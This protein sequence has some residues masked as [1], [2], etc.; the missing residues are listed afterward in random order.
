MKL[1]NKLNL[2][3]PIFEAIKNSG[4]SRGKSDYTATQLIEPARIGALKA[5]HIDELEEDVSNQIFSL[6]GQSVHTILERAAK[7]LN[8][9][10]GAPRYIIEERLFVPLGGLTIS[11]QIDI[12]D[13]KEQILQ[14]YK[15]TSV[16]SVKGKPKK[17]WEEQ[18][19]IGA[20]LLSCQIPSHIVKKLEIVA[21]LRDWSKMEHKRELARGN[22]LGV[23]CT[24]SEHQ[25]VVVDI[26]LWTREKQ[27]A[28]IVKK[29]KEHQAAKKELPECSAEDRWE[30]S[31]KYALMKPGRKSALRLFDTLA[32]AEMA[33]TDAPA[34]CYIDKRP[35]EAIRCENYCPVSN[36]CEQFKKTKE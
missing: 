14:D 23:S 5:K 26:P 12:Y 25:T 9:L 16:H 15:I 27:E 8:K 6:I 32:A 36:F 3:L 7:T 13:I 24:Y 11:G 19:N 20:Y 29:V 18:L 28:F 30:R 33:L 1:T 10:V 21:I 22:I 31:S 2:P 4:Y 34:G 17:E 35:G